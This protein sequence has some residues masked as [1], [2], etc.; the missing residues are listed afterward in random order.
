MGAARGIAGSRAP[1][2]D[3]CFLCRDEGDADCPRTEFSETVTDA[4]RVPMPFPGTDS[5]S[6]RGP[7]QGVWFNWAVTSR[8][9]DR[10]ARR[11]GTSARA[12]AIDSADARAS[13]CG[14]PAG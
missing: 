13:S 4:E 3:G 14:V 7:S 9:A 1:E 5:S 10:R 2:E 6:L 8:P 12:P 11:R